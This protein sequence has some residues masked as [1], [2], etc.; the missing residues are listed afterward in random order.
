[1]FEL[2]TFENIIERMLDSVPNTLDKREGSI[3]YNALAPVAIELTEAYI[4]MD[5]MLDQTFVDTASYYYLEKRCKERGITP[6]S[7]TNTIAK[8]VFNIDIPLDSRFNLGEYN[9]IATERISE[10]IYKMK[11]ETAGPVFE[12]GQLIPIEYI[13][14]L[15]TA[16]LTEILINGEDEE[17]EDSL[18]QRYYNSLNSQSFGG[19]IQNYKDEVNKIQDVGGVKVYPVWAGGG[20]VKLVIINSNFKVPSTDLVNLVQEEIDPNMKGEGL[21]LAPIGH[22][23][24]VEGVTSTTINVSTTITYKSG[25]TWENIKTIAE[26]AIDDYLNEL[27]MSWEDEENLIVRI[28]QIETRLLSIDGVLDIANTM[29][30]DAKSNLT[31]DSNSIVARGEVVG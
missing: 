9:Y 6:L 29:I 18:R 11:C 25:Y 21:G 27:N 1:M 26:E 24:T 16:E 10:G 7:A 4:A 23:V 2:M 12:L 31:I 5:E 15:E 14:K 3:I 17:S 8:G 13:D 19:N 28:S 20:T 22:R 30:N